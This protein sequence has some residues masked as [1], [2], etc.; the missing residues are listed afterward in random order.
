MQVTE[1][2][3]PKQPT[4]EDRASIG[5]EYPAFR[6]VFYL[7]YLSFA[8]P[9]YDLEMITGKQ[10]PDYPTGLSGDHD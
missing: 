3:L 2:S 8:N 9:A 5:A 6:I 1:V 10:L 4:I 7:I